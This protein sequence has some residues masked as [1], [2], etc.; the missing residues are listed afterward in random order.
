[1]PAGSLT[2]PIWE[3]GRLPVSKTAD[4]PAAAIPP[5]T[6]TPAGGGGTALPPLLPLQ[7]TPP[8]LLPAIR[9]I[10][11][12]LPLPHIRSPLQCLPRL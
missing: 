7:A 9:L 6:A 1:M 11:G 5:E 4:F 10:P 2:R 3:E 8:L 12:A